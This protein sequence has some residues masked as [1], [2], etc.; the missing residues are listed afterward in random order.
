[1]VPTLKYS[2]RHGLGCE[3]GSN[4]ADTRI[5]GIPPWLTISLCD[6]NISQDHCLLLTVLL[7]Y[8]PHCT[9]RTILVTLSPNA[10]ITS[11][12]VPSQLDTYFP[13]RYLVP[14]NITRRSLRCNQNM[15]LLPNCYTR[16]TPGYK[17][18]LEYKL[19]F[20]EMANELSTSTS[21]TVL[22]KLELRKGD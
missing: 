16:S 15:A 9:S 7:F 14:S 18:L 8:Y 3:S 12:V 20:N 13:E 21:R 5:P 19:T 11:S 4:S 2:A 1:L 22:R 10:R 6:G 17:L